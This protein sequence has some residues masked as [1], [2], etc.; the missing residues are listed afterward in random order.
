MISLEFVN[1]KVIHGQFAFII[2]LFT[3][4][5]LFK[6]HPKQPLGYL[7]SKLAHPISANGNIFVCGY[8]LSNC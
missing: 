1:F 5:D 6:F 2:G 3:A 8:L 4:K 7:P